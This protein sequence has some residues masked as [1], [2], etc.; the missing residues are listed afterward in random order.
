MKL[1]GGQ[2][3]VDDNKYNM[4]KMDKIV[5]YYE[6]RPATPREYALV[7][8]SFP[9]K[10][11]LSRLASKRIERIVKRD[12]SLCHLCGEPVNLDIEVGPWRPTSD[13]VI[14]R[15]M[16]GGNELSNLR[17]AHASCNNKRGNI[18]MKYYIQ[19]KGIHA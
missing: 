14:P 1:I 11:K 8:K 5:G 7:N 13:H 3:N 4:D 2:E 19:D 17:L 15:S 9:Y 16:G 6:P 10:G 18:L 12:G